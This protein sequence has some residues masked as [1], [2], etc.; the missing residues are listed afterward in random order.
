MQKTCTAKLCSCPVLNSCWV[1]LYTQKAQLLKS[2]DILHSRDWINKALK[3][4][5]EKP[6]ILTFLVELELADDKVA[7]AR[8]IIAEYAKGKCRACTA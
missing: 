4:Q 1:Q 2:S 6:A 8:A 5:P 3:L 7:Q